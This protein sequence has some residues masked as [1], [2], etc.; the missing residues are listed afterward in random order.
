MAATGAVAWLGATIAV[1]EVKGPA[2]VALGVGGAGLIIGLLAL[3]QHQHA[4]LHGL[5]TT[6]AVTGLAN[7]RGFHERLDAAL[8]L[9]RR[10]RAPVALIVIDLDDFKAVNDSH[11]HPYGD[12]VLGTVGERLRATVRPEDVAARIGGEEFALIL[13][14]VEA[15]QALAIAERARAAVA[16]IPVDGIRLTCS[17]G[18]A[19]CPADSDD[20]AV[21]NHLADTA[22]YWAK[23]GG[24][25]RTRRF[26]AGHTPGDW[27]ARQRAEVEAL[28]AS[29]S[30]VHVVYQPIV[31]LATG[32][33]LGYEALARF[34]NASRS[35]PEGWFVQAHGCG[36]GPEL[37]AAA[38]EAALGPTDRPLGTYLALNV[39]P[40]ALSSEVVQRA[41]PRD[42]DGI[43]VEIT[44]HEFVAD[45]GE[46][47]AAIADL[48]A[49]GAKVAIDD[50]GAG[51]A[52]LSQLMRV[53]PDIVKLDRDL[54]DGIH[55]DVA[56]MALVESFVRFAGHIGA[57]VCAEGIE[58]LDDLAATAD[59]DVE[60]AQ[61]YVF[62]HPAGPWTGISPL[63]VEVCRASLDEALRTV[64]GDSQCAVGVDRRLV[65]LSAHLAG[66]R[67]R[68]DLDGALALI[69]A[70]IGADKVV[71]SR[72][73]PSTGIVETLAENGD[74][75]SEEPAYDVSQFP[76]TAHVLDRREVAQVFVG[77]PGADPAEATHLLDMGKRS[78]LMVPVVSRG[79]SLGL[80]EAYSRQDRPWL[81]AEVNRARVI[82]NQ[83]ASVIPAVL[84]GAEPAARVRARTT[85]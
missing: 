70:E 61:G 71:L 11:G 6:D 59:L 64:P 17:A 39:S 82:A 65:R 19:T 23:R 69:S 22:L 60:W 10:E 20:P 46:L 83:F 49:R 36:L 33:V 14:G 67:S 43:V 76:L 54:I 79:E 80:L 58:S 53:R 56:R 12:T 68:G 18:L 37:E 44:E 21:L 26:D 29:D 77:D 40:S 25:N 1:F 4:R 42:L 8:S 57:T 62:A 5:A 41:L 51:Y 27:S 55:D 85:A 50:A 38:I 48:R 9:A 13:Y 3:V 78:L 66:A 84:G 28:L 16:A 52:G 30:P 15:E 45:D 34:P 32:R 73:H 81:R 7:H 72:W 75:A 74:R 24:K 2:L 35:S 47:A 31:A 63:A